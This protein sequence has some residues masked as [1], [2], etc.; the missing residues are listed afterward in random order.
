MQGGGD[1]SLAVVGVA[2]DC[3]GAADESG[4]PVASVCSVD[5]A[6]PA[7]DAT[8]AGAGDEE[9]GEVAGGG[10]PPPHAPTSEALAIHG[11][12]RHG[13]LQAQDDQERIRR[14]VVENGASAS[15]PGCAPRCRHGNREHG[16]DSHP[17]PHS[18][19]QRRPPICAVDA[20]DAVARTK[21]AAARS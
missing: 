9:G 1:G 4:D 6:K 13:E 5:D 17:A 14:S 3:G 10:V 12:R 15:G 11:P 21:G 18:R 2:A 19:S 7:V 8:D 20:D 16:D